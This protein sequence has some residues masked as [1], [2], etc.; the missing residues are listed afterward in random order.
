M[1]DKIFFPCHYLRF[2]NQVQNPPAKVLGFIWL[3]INFTWA[4]ADSINTEL[5][6][7]KQTNTARKNYSKKMRFGLS[8]TFTDVMK[9][10]WL[11]QTVVA[12]FGQGWQNGFLEDYMAGSMNN[13]MN[14]AERPPKFG[15]Q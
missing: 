11:C 4:R 2:S 5:F 9:L 1:F 10:T 13:D 6:I 8:F 12:M 15:F 3:T 14:R 7:S